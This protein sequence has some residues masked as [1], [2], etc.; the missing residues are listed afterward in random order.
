MVNWSLLYP[1]PTSNIYV[2]PAVVTVNIPLTND[3]IFGLLS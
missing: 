1:D 3:L 2:R